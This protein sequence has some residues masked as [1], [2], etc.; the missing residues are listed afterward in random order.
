MCIY[1]KYIQIINVKNIYTH[2]L[3]SSGW[4]A[5][6]PSQSALYPLPHP[7]SRRLKFFLKL[8]H[9]KDLCMSK[10]TPVLVLM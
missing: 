1:L 2:T 7:T 3:S 5:L 4:A 10:N 9:L 8:Q 6:N